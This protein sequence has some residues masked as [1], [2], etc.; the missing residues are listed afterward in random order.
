M[1]MKTRYVLGHIFTLRFLYD[2]T[3]LLTLGRVY[4]DQ[5]INGYSFHYLNPPRKFLKLL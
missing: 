4:G 2:L 1:N 3:I 5:K